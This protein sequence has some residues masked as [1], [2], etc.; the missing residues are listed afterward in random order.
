MPEPTDGI[1]DWQHSTA[2][3]AGA[4]PDTEV[5]HPSPDPPGRCEV[6]VVGAGL[7]GL[8]A[9]INL[10][11][12]GREVVVL[13]GARVGSGTTGHS[14]A[15]LTLLQGAQFQKLAAIAGREAVLGHIEANRVG[16]AWLV[17]VL[18]EAGSPPPQA[19]AIS[20][21]VTERG[22]RGLA[23]ELEI[24]RAAGLPVEQSADAG[25]PFPTIAAL[26]LPDQYALDPLRVLYALRDTFTTLGG[27][28]V[29]DCL[30]TGIDESD[31]LWRL[32]TD[33]GE[34]TAESVVIATG[35]PSL[36]KGR[37]SAWVE[38]NRS[39]VL[40]YLI[41]LAEVPSGMFLS[42]D[43]E[44][45]SLRTADVEGGVL[46]VGG[47]GHPVGQG[48]SGPTGAAGLHT[49]A[50]SWFPV[51]EPRW[52]WSAQDYRHV[53]G[54]PVVETIRGRRGGVVLATGYDKWGMA[55]AAAAA[56]AITAEV[57]GTADDPWARDPGGRGVLL[58]LAKRSTL[59]ALRWSGGRFAGVTHVGDDAPAEGE[60]QVTGG[61]LHPVAVST[62][63]GVTR[64]VSAVCPHLWG[65]VAWNAAE[66]RWDCPLHGSRFT[67]DGRRLEGPAVS[68]LADAPGSEKP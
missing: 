47:N 5:P 53:G 26:T 66:C 58:S 12:A 27:T 37:T 41:D 2:W 60:G 62:V 68:D 9:A 67:P 59:N 48:P 29:E 20:Y 25:L 49:W 11:R 63:H 17:D 40:G 39:Y 7:T 45:R 52:S 6:A 23:A 32:V 28:V 65:V 1:R 30:V 44:V 4:G 36:D 57:L 55:N 21:A 13:E 35:A 3:R 42:V 51:A 46:L 18:T 8:S 54:I 10:A 43:D 22:A 19:P 64:R 61:P 56:L 33:R 31:D 16:Q 50:R 38:A 14:S 15:K 34:V 24:V